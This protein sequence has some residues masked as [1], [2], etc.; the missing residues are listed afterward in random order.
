MTAAVGQ[1][2]RVFLGR[3]GM[4]TGM[5]VL[6]AGIFGMHILSGAHDLHAAAPSPVAATQLD[7]YGFGGGVEERT[8]K[9]LTTVAAE[10][11][12]SV[13]DVLSAC[14]DPATCPT[15]SAPAQECIPAPASTAF[16]APEPGAALPASRMGTAAGPRF[17]Y[18]PST[19]GPS[20]G[21]LGISRT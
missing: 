12:T 18:E 1:R 6:I 9:Q 8:P 4:L 3:A 14:L 13:Y 5:L 2:L 10:P 17:C 11:A 16:E 21:T 7:G 20:P 19:S 15:M